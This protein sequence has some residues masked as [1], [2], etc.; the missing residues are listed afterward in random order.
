MFG[1]A[2]W[3]SQWWQEHHVRVSRADTIA[4]SVV[5]VVCWRYVQ[6]HDAAARKHGRR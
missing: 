5:M 4:I 1:W 2:P 3:S 6:G